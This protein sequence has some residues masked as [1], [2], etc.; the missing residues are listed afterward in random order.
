VYQ[1]EL[2]PDESIAPGG[3]TVETPAMYV[4]AQLDA[5]I[6]RILDQLSEIQCEPPES[7]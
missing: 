5:Q 7:Q 2:I 6:E 3:C 1:K 4:D